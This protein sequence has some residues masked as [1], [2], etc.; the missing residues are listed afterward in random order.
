MRSRIQ[1]RSD[2]CSLGVGLF[3]RSIQVLTE[4]SV[5]AE[6]DDSQMARARLSDQMADG[7]G[8]SGIIRLGWNTRPPVKSDSFTRAKATQ[9]RACLMPKSLPSIAKYKMRESL[10]AAPGHCRR[11]KPRHVD[12]GPAGRLTTAEE[13]M[14][15]ATRLVPSLMAMAMML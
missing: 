3:R 15:K 8:A 1:R 4:P 13:R 10:R 7:P 14:S 12:R 11:R 2:M 5:P 9:A 6:T